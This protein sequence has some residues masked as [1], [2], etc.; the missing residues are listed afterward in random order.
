MVALDDKT[1]YSLS[2]YQTKVPKRV[3]KGPTYKNNLFYE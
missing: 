3:H 1:E 2:F